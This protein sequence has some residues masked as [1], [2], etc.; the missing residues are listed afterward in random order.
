MRAAL[1]TG[2]ESPG[3]TRHHD[4]NNTVSNSLRACR[5]KQAFF[6]EFANCCYA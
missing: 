5:K 4:N 3:G 6:Y 2:V 1:L